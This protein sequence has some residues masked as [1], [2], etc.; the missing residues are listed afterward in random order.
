MNG[1]YYGGIQGFNDTTG[2][3]LWQ[4][5]ADWADHWEPAVNGEYV[6]AP[7][8]GDITA[9]DHESGEVLFSIDANISTQ[10]FVLGSQNKVITYG[11]QLASYHIGTQT[12]RWST[13]AAGGSYQMPAVGNGLV[14]TVQDNLLKAFNELNGELVWQWTPSQSLQSNIVL[15]ASHVFVA[16]NSTT[17]AL[18][19]RTQDVD[20][21]F[22]Q[23]GDLSLGREGALVISSGTRIKVIEVGRSL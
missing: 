13:S 19:L 11:A 4:G 5:S 15:T 21:E 22:S 3:H 23:G 1:G 17:F 2:E 16:S 10:T 12:A 18:N 6:F 9:L 8:N 7:N 14:I 20:W